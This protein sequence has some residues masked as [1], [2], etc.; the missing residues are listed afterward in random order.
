MLFLVLQV[1]PVLWRS[2][3]GPGAFTN[4][5]DVVATVH[6]APSRSS[7]SSHTVVQRQRGR[8]YSLCG[9]MDGTW[10]PL[11]RLYRISCGLLDISGSPVASSEQGSHSALAGVESSSSALNS[12]FLLFLFLSTLKVLAIL[13][14]FHMEIPNLPALALA[15]L[16]HKF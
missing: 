7:H 10:E 4:F 13:P 15:F 8:V 14:N 1:L 6:L 3:E 9:G 2:L 11:G 16:S 12:R 5:A